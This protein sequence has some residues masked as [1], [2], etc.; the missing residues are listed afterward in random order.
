MEK[1]K[2]EKYWRLR[3]P[4]FLIFMVVMTA[5]TFCVYE[6]RMCKAQ[7]PSAVTQGEKDHKSTDNL[8][9]HF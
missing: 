5:I 9:K 8:I 6:A 7:T 1:E 3:L 2:L 4:I